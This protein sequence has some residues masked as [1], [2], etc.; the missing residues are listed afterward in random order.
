MGGSSSSGRYLSNVSSTDI[1]WVGRSG[2]T[3][4]FVDTPGEVVG[5][6]LLLLIQPFSK[7][8]GRCRLMKIA[9]SLLKSPAPGSKDLIIC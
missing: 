8:Y 6:Q 9:I 7:Y 3:F 5:D 4:P 1:D 2:T